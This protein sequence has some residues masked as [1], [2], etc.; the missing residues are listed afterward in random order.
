MGLPLGLNVPAL[1]AMNLQPPL[2]PMMLPPPPYDGAAAGYPPMN[3]QADLLAKQHLVLQ[4]Q[5]AAAVSL[6]I[7]FNFLLIFEFLLPKSHFY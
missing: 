2:V 7:F 3:A 4:Q 5:Q 6:D 1:A